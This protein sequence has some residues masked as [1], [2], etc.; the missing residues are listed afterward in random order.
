MPILTYKYRLFPNQ[1]QA[2][3]L[4]DML[5]SFCDLYNACLQQRIEAY[6]RQGKTLN[7]YDQANEL[8]AV[9]VVDDRLAS[10]S[11]SA[12][13]QVVRRL[14][15]AFKAFFGRVR[16][17]KGGFPRFRAKSMFDSADFRVGDGL[18]IRKSKKLGIVGIPGEIKVRWHREFP[19]GAKVG[20]AVL[21]RSCGKWYICF[22]I[23][24]PDAYGPYPLRAVVGI[25]IGLTSLIAT[26]AG[27]TVPTPKWVGQASKKQRRLQRAL[28]RCKRASKGR[29]KAK[30]NLARHSA[31]VANQRRDFS[32]KLSRALVDQYSHIAF[33]DLNI[34]GLARGMLAKSVLN[35]AW[36][37]LISFTDY[38]AANAGG[39]VAKVNPRG[40]SQECDCC[41]LVTPKTLA[42]R[43]HDC[44]GCGTVEDRD[45]HAAKVIKHRAFPWT[46]RLGASLG[47]SSQPVAA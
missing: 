29:L 3:G 32:R 44:P 21:S 16:R 2:S 27:D 23:E 26:S 7:F 37:Q 18:T 15:K 19:V 10:Y 12:E 30:R 17:G 35:A 40:T 8:K 20:T 42:D 39:L 33:E 11:F 24:T 46:K 4:T 34:T 31:H 41:G 47:A 28:A 1:T 43:I 22:S 5:G 14:D 9:R 38:K 6:Q 13:Q 25:D 36:A 45:V